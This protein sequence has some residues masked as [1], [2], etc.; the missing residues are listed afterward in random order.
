MNEFVKQAIFAGSFA[1]S[2]L[3]MS[4]QA[5]AHIA[6]DGFVV[7]FDSDINGA[8]MPAAVFPRSGEFYNEE[9][10]I[11][12]AIG[13]GSAPGLENSLF[14]TSSGTSH[15]HGDTINDSRTSSLEPDAGGGM[16]ELGDK[17]PFSLLGMD[18]AKL[19]LSLVGGR[20]STMTIR[21]YTSADF[22][23]SH[24]VIIGEAG[25]NPVDVAGGVFD[26]ET[27]ADINGTH[28]HFDEVA[29]FGELYLVEYFF[30]A[31]GRATNPTLISNFDNLQVALDN[32]EFGPVV[33]SVPV[34]A[35]VYLL[36]TALLGLGGIRKKQ[37]IV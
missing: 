13:F 21:G 24:D 25:G 36:G 3:G 22:S 15:L 20:T 16:F 37:V 9:N 34:P 31:P 19:D 11:H 14:Q 6:A 28:L 2:L 8:F 35:A 1:V 23:S 12:T 18:I 30:D 32:V 17:A 33:S 7:G 29:E 5:A 27:G 4:G 10:M 26:T